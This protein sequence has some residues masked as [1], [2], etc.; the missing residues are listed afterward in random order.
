MVFYGY[1]GGN[2][3]PGGSAQGLVTTGTVITMNG[4]P[5]YYAS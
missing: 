2:L 4:S 3:L 5:S 1:T